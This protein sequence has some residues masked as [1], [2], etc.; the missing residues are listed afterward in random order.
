[1]TDTTEIELRPD[2]DELKP[3]VYL[4]EGLELKAGQALLLRALDAENGEDL[5]SVPLTLLVDWD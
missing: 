2:V 4:R 5:G 3:P 1:M